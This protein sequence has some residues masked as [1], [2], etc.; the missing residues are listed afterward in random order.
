VASPLRKSASAPGDLPLHSF[1]A[2][3]PASASTSVQ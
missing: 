1:T 2:Q 3:T